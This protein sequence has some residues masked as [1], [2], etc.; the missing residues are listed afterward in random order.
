MS[1]YVY[2]IVPENFLYAIAIKFS[3]IVS[4]EESNIIMIRNI[5]YNN[6]SNLITTI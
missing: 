5:D 2:A 4:I 6:M 3:C 1:N